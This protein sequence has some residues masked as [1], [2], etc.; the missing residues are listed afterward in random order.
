M[1]ARPANPTPLAS[2]QPSCRWSR[3]SGC[4]AC[5]SSSSATLPPPGPNQVAL[6]FCSI[7]ATY[8]A[9]RHGHSVAALRE[10]AVT[11]VNTGL[12]AIF[13]LLA[14]G[15][16][17]GTWALSGT[18]VAMVYYGL[19]LLSPDYFYVT[20]CLICAMVAVSIGSSWTVAGTIGIGLM[21]VA[22]KMGLDPT[23]TAGAIISGAY[24]GDKS[25]PL[26]DTANLACAAAGANLY[27]H[28]R[29]SLWTSVPAL[30]IAVLGFGLLG[31]PGD[32]DAV[33]GI[34]GDRG[35]L[36]PLASAL[37]AAPA[38]ARAGAAA[39]AALRHHLPRR[40]RRR[41]P[42]RRH[43]AGS[44]HRLRRRGPARRPRAP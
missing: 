33:A 35:R 42:R 11:S 36:P 41:R 32:F 34:G 7:V 27:D 2:R 37:P 14:V 18:L 15:A 44:G 8:V 28:V 13:I 9:W 10:A 3:W 22:Q 38:R 23:I 26:S 6:V 30:A 16:L 20:A 39:L 21:G 5:P 12:T 25:S 1:F 4:S 19:K 17:I 29:E 43:G 40:P 24:F 31:A